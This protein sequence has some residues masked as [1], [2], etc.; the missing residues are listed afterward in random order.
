MKDATADYSD[1]EMH[2]ALAVKLPNYASAV[3][4]TKEI[5]ASLA[6]PW[7]ARGSAVS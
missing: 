1:E 2:A 3:V 7:N 5:I 4:T 6:S